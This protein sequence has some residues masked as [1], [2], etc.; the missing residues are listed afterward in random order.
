ME[1]P[2]GESGGMF[3]LLGRNVSRTGRSVTEN[4]TVFVYMVH[5][6]IRNWYYKHKTD[7]VLLA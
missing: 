4:I 2:V 3:E 7:K 1:A 5:T 6:K